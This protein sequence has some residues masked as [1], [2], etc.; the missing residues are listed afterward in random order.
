MTRKRLFYDIETSFCEGWFYRPDW[1]T[2]IYPHQIKEHAKIISIHWKFEGEDK[3]HNLHWGLNKQCDK[4]MLKKFIKVLDSATEVVHYNGKKFDTPWLR[5]RAMFHG[6]EFKHSYNEVD[7]YSLVK[8]YLKQLPDKRLKGVCDYFNLP[9]KLDAGG[10]MTWVNV[11]YNKDQEALDHLLYYGDGDITSLEAVFQKLRPY[12][13]S[14]T[15]YHIDLVDVG[16]NKLVSSKF[17]CPECGGLLQWNKEYVTKS[18]TVQHY[19]KCR[20]KSCATYHKIS[21]RDYM[22]YIKYTMKNNIK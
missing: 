16:D 1:N 19:M 17:F 10:H 9:S 6:L 13:D 12:V 2:R 22:N 7:C 14:N 5:Q 21:N 8:K 20:D 3:I 11:I 4:A 18:G 15:H